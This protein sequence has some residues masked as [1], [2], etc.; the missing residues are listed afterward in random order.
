MIAKQNKWHA[1]RYGMGATFMDFDTLQAIP[2]RE[3]AARLIRRC[4]PFAEQLESSGHLA[5]LDDIIARGT[6]AD[7][8]RDVYRRTGDLREVVRAMLEESRMREE[9]META[10]QGPPAPPARGVRSHGP[11]RRA[12][13]G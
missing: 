10:P 6:G 5:H 3:A 9:P 12:Q 13:A 7:R 8:Q 11:E 4:Q 2:A 1:A